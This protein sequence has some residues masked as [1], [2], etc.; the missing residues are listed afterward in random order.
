[1]PQPKLNAADV[2]RDV[3]EHL[4]PAFSLWPSDRVVILYLLR[5]S[6][7]AGQRT[8]LMPARTLS[9]ATLLSRSTV[10]IALR[11]LAARGII[12]ILKRDYSGLRIAVKL[13]R[14][15]P[16]CVSESRLPDGRLLDSLDFWTSRNRRSAIFRRD[17][18]RCFYCLRRLRPNSR[19]LDHVIPRAAAGSSHARSASSPSR[20][21]A[22]RAV[23]PSPPRRTRDLHFPCANSR[24]CSRPPARFAHLYVNGHFN[25]N[26]YRNLVACCPTC[27]MLKR[28]RP[29]SALLRD[30][31]RSGLL[32]L[33]GFSSRRR[34]LC[35]LITGTNKP[36]ILTPMGLVTFS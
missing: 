5:A 22:K 1:L 36:P 8:I 17:G 31:Y 6:R 14:E 27:N 34:A 33:S 23:I 15:I 26:S 18:N 19:V 30:L 3:E 10:R 2:W 16:G 11:R 24:R 4:T 35:L 28:D 13:P 7:L 32:S 21:R 12:R 20:P 29:A 9:R 25:F